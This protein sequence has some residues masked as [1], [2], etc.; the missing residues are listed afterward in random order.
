MSISFNYY[1]MSNLQKDW[2]HAYYIINIELNYSA[3]VIRLSITIIKLDIL[4]II[5]HFSANSF[6]LENDIATLWLIYIQTVHLHR[7]CERGVI[8]TKIV[9][10]CFTQEYVY[11]IPYF[12]FHS[13]FRSVRFSDPRFSITIVQC[14]CVASEQ[15]LPAMM[16]L[17]E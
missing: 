13:V 6:T 1:V 3:L 16:S 15:I 9:Y 8:R 2:G 10:I 4:A 17:Y 7:Q 12:S 5:Q 14:P 11:H